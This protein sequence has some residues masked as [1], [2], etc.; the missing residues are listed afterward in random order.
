MTSW[1]TVLEDRKSLHH[2]HMFVFLGVHFTA[3]GVLA[4]VMNAV[5]VCI[6]E[7]ELC[8]IYFLF[9][10]VLLIAENIT[11]PQLHDFRL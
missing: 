5:N 4:H 11:L 6:V 8:F 3:F 7:F 9:H 10:L 1:N 2:F